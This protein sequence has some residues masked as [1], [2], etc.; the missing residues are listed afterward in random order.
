MRKA[1]VLS[2][3]QLIP[4]MLKTNNLEINKTKTEK[5]NINIKKRSD[6]S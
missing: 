6:E 4:P 1:S 3:E 2:G 5:Y